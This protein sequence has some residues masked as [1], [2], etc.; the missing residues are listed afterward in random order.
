MRAIVVLDT[1]TSA[2]AAVLSRWMSSAPTTALRYLITLGAINELEA[3]PEKDREAL[4]ATIAAAEKEIEEDPR[5][6]SHTYLGEKAV[7]DILERALKRLAARGGKDRERAR[8]AAE[9]L[10]LEPP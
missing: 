7:K 9:L 5:Y 3:L 2:A 8:R 4:V 6:G 1:R 10:H